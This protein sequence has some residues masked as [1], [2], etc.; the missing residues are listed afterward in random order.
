MILRPVWSSHPRHRS[1]TASLNGHRCKLCLSCTPDQELRKCSCAPPASEPEEYAQNTWAEGGVGLPT[2]PPLPPERP[3][4]STLVRLS[5][6]HLTPSDLSLK[7]ILGA[8]HASNLSSR[9]RVD[10]SKAGY[11]LKPVP[12]TPCPSSRTIRL[13]DVSRL[14]RPAEQV[15]CIFVSTKA[16]I[17]CALDGPFRRQRTLP[18]FRDLR[19]S[20]SPFTPLRRRRGSTFSSGVSS[21]RSPTS[22]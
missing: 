19:S 18:L 3:P 8:P 5:L 10:Y 21:S 4:A 9:M 1:G 20:L 14:T 6:A 17:A 2:A 15:V 16:W 12:G 7:W 11:P 13:S 22:I